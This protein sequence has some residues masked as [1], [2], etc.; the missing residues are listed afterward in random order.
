MDLKDILA[1]SLPSLS[2]LVGILLNRSDT[3]RLDARLTT[4]V[5]RITAEIADLKK[6]IRDLRNDIASFRSDQREFY[7]TLGQHEVR[8][9]NLE[10]K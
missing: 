2:V 3:N 6:D 1:I 10:K 4:E 7:R 8:I 5:S 9:E